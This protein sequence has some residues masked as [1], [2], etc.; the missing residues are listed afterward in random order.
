MFSCG[1]IVDLKKA[2]DTVDHSVVLNNRGH[3]EVLSMTGFRLI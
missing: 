2:F 1:L 3:A